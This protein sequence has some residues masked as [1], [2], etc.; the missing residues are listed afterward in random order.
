VF[1][2]LSNVQRLTDAFTGAKVVI[3]LIHG[4][5]AVIGEREGFI[6]QAAIA[7]KTVQ[8]FVPSEFGC[9]TFAMKP[10]FGKL[11]DEKK[12]FQQKLKDLKMDFT[13][14][15]AGLI[16][17]YSLPNLREFSEI[18]TYG[19]LDLEYPVASCEDI[20]TVTV[21]A[22][23]DPRCVNK[24]VQIKANWV[25]QADFIPLLK[26]FWPNYEFSRKHMDTKEVLH[27]AEHGD[28]NLPLE[29][30]ELERHQINR[31]CYVVPAVTGSFRHENLPIPDT[32]DAQE[33]FPDILFKH[34]EHVLADPMFVFGKPL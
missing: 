13:I 18:T 20:G 27:L 28:P 10:G 31:A 16:F 34:P 5:S 23:V 3:S 1:C 33:L 8:R 32:L 26:K 21:R 19:D 30:P 25:K 14:I 2:D 15:F 6:L 12:K 29:Q 4:T 9:N 22:A 11:F 24:G 7:A 17:D